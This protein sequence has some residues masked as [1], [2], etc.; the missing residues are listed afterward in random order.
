MVGGVVRV[1]R[2]TYHRNG[3]AGEGFF[4]VEFSTR[5]GD[6]RNRKLLGIVTET[7]VAV[8]DRDNPQ[9]CWRGHDYYADELRH[10][11]EVAS[12]TGDAHRH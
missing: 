3:V 5:K 1:Q 8:V 2:V 12:L 9:E 10:A 6:W 11:C 4:T 7:L